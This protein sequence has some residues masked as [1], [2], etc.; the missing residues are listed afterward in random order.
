MWGLLHHYRA[1]R[2]AE[3]ELTIA[4]RWNHLIKLDP[5]RRKKVTHADTNHFEWHTLWQVT[6]QPWISLALWGSV[7]LLPTG[8]KWLINY[9]TQASKNLGHHHQLYL[10][11]LPHVCAT[12]E[13]HC[14]VISP[15]SVHFFFF[16]WVMLINV[17]CYCC[18]MITNLIL[19]QTR[20][21]VITA[22]ITRSE[23]GY[24][25]GGGGLHFCCHFLSKG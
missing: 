19:M 15:P 17:I 9:L 10:T 6:E 20:H 22:L 4:R 11:V 16:L 18:K 24:E 1:E 7:A 5:S 25:G 13:I 3:K 14:L 21:S 23:M 8:L 2:V 12:Q